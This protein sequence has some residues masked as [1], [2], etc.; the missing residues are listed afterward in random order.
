MLPNRSLLLVLLSFAVPFGIACESRTQATES[1]DSVT[2]VP[3]SVASASASSEA[4]P[5]EVASIDEAVVRKVLSRW[6][7]AQNQGDLAAYE[8]LFA[9]R[10]TGI[11]RSGPRTQRFNRAGWLEDR[12]P[13]FERSFVVTVKDLRI[14]TS[15]T[16]VI[17]E[18]EQTFKTAT[19]EDTGPKR[20]IL[21]TEGDELRISNEEMLA[22]TLGDGAQNAE[23]VP[24]P[25]DFSFVHGDDSSVLLLG[26][27]E[28]LRAVTGHPEY[29]DDEHATRPVLPSALPEA[30]RSLIGERFALYGEDAKVCEG[31]V[32]SL[33][34]HVAAEPHFGTVQAWNGEGGIP[35]AS[36]ARRALELWNL[37][38]WGGRFLAAKLKLDKACGGAVWARSTSK[39][40]PLLYRRRA[41]AAGEDTAIL[42]AVRAHSEYKALQREFERV[43]G[44]REP[45]DVEA[46]RSIMLFEHDK[47][48]TFVEVT[49]SATLDDGC[50]S[51]FDPD[52]WVLLEARGNAYHVVS[53]PMDAHVGSTWPRMLGPLGVAS[54]FD[55]E[56]DG[57]VEFASRSD[58]VRAVQGKFRA[59]YNLSPGYYSCPC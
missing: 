30:Q 27:L 18:F 5:T 34:V 54:A 15:P 39:H 51:E 22:S 33:F 23:A 8:A 56:G 48:A 50:A 55:L 11:K 36:N 32:E 10:F 14:T 21:V 1:K 41:P 53:A 17:A 16:M 29:V 25:R 45:W 42:D 59:V 40:E 31:V 44:K 24:D 52:L 3:S 38:E 2:P 13:M 20:I 19:Y 12:K 7:S 9:K 35:K 58:F 46:A 4:I 43:T 6:E 26:A 47:R 49:L 57:V 37:S 28:D